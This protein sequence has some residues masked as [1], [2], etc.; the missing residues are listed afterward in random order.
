[1]EI[2]FL[3]YWQFVAIV[4]PVASATPNN[5]TTTNDDEQ[6]D[7]KSRNCTRRKDAKRKPD[8]MARSPRRMESASDTRKA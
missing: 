1:V 4:S 7:T 3:T 8:G 6:S 5:N 2:S